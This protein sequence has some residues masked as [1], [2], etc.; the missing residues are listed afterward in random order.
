LCETLLMEFRKANDL[1]IRRSTEK[2]FEKLRATIADIL[3]ACLSNLKYYIL[4]E[5]SKSTC[6][7]EVREAAPSVLTFFGDTEKI[8]E[9]IETREIPEM[10][11]EKMVFIIIGVN[12]TRSEGNH[13][14]SQHK[15]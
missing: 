9:I 2:L 6:I 15:G 11:W 13:L 1:T 5:C 4:T 14:N 8:M 12:I 10:S 7:E 3:G